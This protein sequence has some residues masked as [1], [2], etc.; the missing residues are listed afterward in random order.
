MLVAQ[1]GYK[2][3]HGYQRVSVVILIMLLYNACHVTQRHCTDLNYNLKQ[4][5]T[6]CFHGYGHVSNGYRCFRGL[7][8]RGHG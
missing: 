4:T 2:S 7:Q 3:Y 6:K 5:K 8:M 1:W